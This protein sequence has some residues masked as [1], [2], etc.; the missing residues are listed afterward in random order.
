VPTHTHYSNAETVTYARMALDHPRMRSDVKVSAM[1][2]YAAFGKNYAFTKP[3]GS[4]KPLAAKDE[5]LEKMF[6]SLK[7]TNPLRSIGG[8]APRGHF[9]EVPSLATL[10]TCIHAKIA[11]T[12]GAYGY[13]TLR[14]RL[15]D[16]ANHEG[17][18]HKEDVKTIFR[19][20][21]GLTPEEVPDEYLDVYL[22]QHATMK[23]TELKIG[24]FMTSL[25]P[26]LQ[27]KEKRRVL[28]AFK[29]LNPVN[30]EI[31]LGDWL[32]QLQDDELRATVVAAFGA[33]DEEQVGGMAVN[34]QVFMELFADIA[35]FIA[36][37]PLIAG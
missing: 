19:D 26:V 14:Q 20:Q 22:S 30:G 11:E 6:H 35:P 2:G 15:F 29:A 7:D 31:R 12:W 4:F 36:I 24:N 28:E 21:L 27:Q 5:E 18:V 9:G 16:V 25:R 34:D 23:K 32:G 1:T 10:K 8:H 17:Y 37:D 33:Q 13:V 3:T